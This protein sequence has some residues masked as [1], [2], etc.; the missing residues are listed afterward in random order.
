MSDKIAT[1]YD[2]ALDWV[3]LEMG[4]KNWQDK[5]MVEAGH[6]AQR[7][8]DAVRERNNYVEHENAQLREE[9]GVAKMLHDSSQNDIE[10]LREELA[11]MQ[12]WQSKCR[13]QEIVVEE[14]RE[15]LGGVGTDRTYWQGRALHLKNQWH[16]EGERNVQLRQELEEAL[17]RLKEEYRKGWDDGAAFTAKLGKEK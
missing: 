16:E 3:M 13:T 11:D 15:Q 17:A 2:W 4:L 5:R 12:T 1:L 7:L 14:L 6:M 10:R 8:K 9:L